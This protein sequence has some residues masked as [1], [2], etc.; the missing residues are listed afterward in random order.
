VLG[1]DRLAGL[2]IDEL[3]A[4]AIAGALLICRKA[5]RSAVEQAAWS[6]ATAVLMIVSGWLYSR[7]RPAGFWATAVLC[8]AAVPVIWTLH[9]ALSMLSP[10]QLP[11]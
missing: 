10:A 4:Q 5:M 7:L 3:L 6:G 2:F 8:I 9:R 1:G 11:I